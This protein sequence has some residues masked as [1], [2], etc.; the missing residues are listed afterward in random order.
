MCGHLGL[1]INNPADFLAAPKYRIYSAAKTAVG[2]DIAAQM[3]LENQ[4][5]R[6]GDGFGVM[7]LSTLSVCDPTVNEELRTSFVKKVDNFVGKWESV[8]DSQAVF[9]RKGVICMHARKMTA[10]AKVYA[11]THPIHV[12]H[13]TLMHNGSVPNWQRIFPKAASDTIGIAQL[14]AEEGIKEVAETV[15]GAK[16]LVWLDSDDKSLNFFKHKERPLFMCRTGSSY[17][18]A[19]EKWMIFK[20][21]DTYDMPMDEW[22]EFEDGCHYQYFPETGLWADVIKYQ[23]PPVFI[24]Y[25][26]STT[27]ISKKKET[28]SPSAMVGASAQTQQNGK[29]AGTTALTTTLSTPT[30]DMSIL[31]GT[32]L[33]VQLLSATIDAG[34]T[35][36]RARIVDSTSYP[37]PRGFEMKQVRIRVPEKLA[38][39]FVKMCKAGTYMVTSAAAATHA[40]SEY[41]VGEYPHLMLMCFDLT[42]VE[43]EFKN[44]GDAAMLLFDQIGNDP[45]PPTLLSSIRSYL[46]WLDAF[47]VDKAAPLGAV[48]TPHKHR[49]NCMTSTERLPI[50]YI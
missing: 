10:G 11:A 12:G 4:H 19:S 18:Y 32:K 35:L 41:V 8:V 40:S 38:E 34:M 3:L 1:V 30:N 27:Y 15:D 33:A 6:G 21:L 29:I 28:V 49:I 39:A 43:P 16:T 42:M 13:I 36:V 37:A 5:Y 48:L 46:E 23:D 20:A 44:I 26:V 45:C 24:S 25:P 22:L 50:P 9:A 7:A 14:L 2:A 47:E 31:R 17:V